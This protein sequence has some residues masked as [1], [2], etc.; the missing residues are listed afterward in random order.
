MVT[1]IW[2]RTL[3]FGFA[4][5]FAPAVFA[6]YRAEEAA[7]SAP[8]P[9]VAADATAEAGRVIVTGSNIP[10]AEEVGPNPVDTFRQE[11]I[12]K[13]GVRT[14]T[15]LVQRMPAVFGA[16]ENENQS[17][18]A[19]GT[20][21]VSLRG[22]DP[23]ETLIL[24]DG[25]RRVNIGLAGPFVDFNFFSIG[26][27]DHVDLLK[28]GA[29]PVYGTDAVAG[30]VNVFLLHKFH[31]TEVYSSYGN[32]NLG[33]AHDMAQ[34]TAYVLAGAGDSKTEIVVYAGVFDQDS[35]FSRD[36]PVSRDLDYVHFG[37]QDRRS[38]NFS[39]NISDPQNDFDPAFD[40]VYQ[41]SLNGGSLTPT[42]HA[43]PNLESN[44]QYVAR[45]TLPRE[46]QLF[47]IADYSS[48]LPEARR[49]Y[50][51]GSII[52][53]L[54]GKSLTLF[55]D[56]NI[57]HQ[58]WQ[59]VLAPTPFDHDIWTDADHPF[60]IT[61]TGSGFSVPL[62]NPFNPFTT[63]DY[64]SAGGFDP[65]V[66]SSQA[67]A[68]PAGTDFTRGVRFR[69]LEAGPRGPE[70]STSNNLL[71]AGLR[72]SLADTATTWDVLRSWDW[73][74]AVRWNED[75][76]INR[77]HN[78]VDDNALR[79]ALLNTNPAT[80]FNPFGLNQNP[81]SVIDR[82]FV[83]TTET[84]YASLW[85]G[86][87]KL[88]GNL[89]NTPGGPVSF[90][91]GTEYATD[92]LSDRP[93]AL[94]ASGQVTG[95]ASFQRTVG[96][97]QSWSEYWE[98]RIPITGSSWNVPGFRSLEFDYA[99]RFESFSDFGETERPKFSLRWQPFGGSSPPLTLR[100]SYI[101]AF[102]APA[103]VEL[104]GGT[105]QGTPLIDDPVT[106]NFNQ[107][108]VDFTSNPNLEPETAYERTFGAVL[109]PETWWSGLRGLT[110]S[111]DYGHIDLR[112]F[113]TQL[114]PQYI[115]DHESE[116]PGL[117]Q[118][119]PTAGN[120]IVHIHDPILNLGRLIETYFD[121]SVVERFETSRLGSDWGTFTAILNGTYLAD[122]DIQTVPNGKRTTV[123][124]KYF[125][126]AA[127]THNRFNV[128]FFYDGARGT[129]LEGFDAG[130]TIHFVGQ[131]WDDRDFTSDGQPRKVREW[132]PVDLILNYTFIPRGVSPS[133]EVPGYAKAGASARSPD[134]KGLSSI[135]TA[136]Y[137]PSGWQ[138]WLKNTTIT[139]GVNNVFNL[140]P[141]FVAA[142]T[143]AAGSA[144][145]GY[146][147]TSANP[148]G[149]FWYVALKKRFF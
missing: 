31:G 83:T 48:A 55:A 2:C 96:D 89:F 114:D 11:D 112:S 4:L 79:A 138:Q 101:E 143:Q 139:V 20:T 91:V 54:F 14:P 86:D 24:Q 115:V 123:V 92:D 84:G 63:A 103:L 117:V 51:Y 118:R 80:A 119:D 108:L 19:N 41:P 27:T 5:L 109:T 130:A 110:I 120:Q 16:G 39:G 1:R 62:Q 17:S 87:F 128:S 111:V 102:H 107:V 65:H 94:L 149:R 77:F 43:F 13:L 135:S 9:P 26:L 44:P 85:T 126:G 134:D 18:T 100:A 72:G 78:A 3:V 82:I 127:Y 52:R 6:Q 148:K 34:R 76:R 71:T 23:K 28:D 57:Y 70:V 37:G 59:A 124:G 40:L 125:N 99:E 129:R 46:K 116:F 22:F 131:F 30:V 75:Y 121:Y 113:S 88:S 137:S 74:T 33:F 36:I 144:E 47:N 90:A 29:S 93:D 104:F 136:E 97:R 49:D 32:T 42:P 147:E 21:N 64:T 68:A 95:L 122:L 45:S 140:Q 146:D 81:Q 67:S 25:R 69:G 56:F 7:P 8:T 58:K 133:G 53:D 105:L 106:G 15:D 60:G 12:I 50:Y 141:P 142:A 35:I 10:T 98:F 38:R 145:N 132:M 61:P 73:E 66:P